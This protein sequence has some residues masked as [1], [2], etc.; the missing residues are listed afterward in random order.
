VCISTSRGGEPA[1]SAPFKSPWLS[2][3]GLL[4]CPRFVDLQQKIVKILLDNPEKRSYNTGNFIP[5][6]P[7]RKSSTL[8]KRTIQ[9]ASGGESEAE[10]GKRMDF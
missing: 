9:R 1:F 10:S 5:K 3:R 7:V 2:S 4:I 8:H 6:K